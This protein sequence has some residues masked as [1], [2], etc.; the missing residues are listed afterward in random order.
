MQKCEFSETQ[1]FIGYARELFNSISSIYRIIA[2]STL[3]EKAY[4]ADLILEH[5][6]KRH[7][8]KFSVYYQFKRSHLHNKEI[9]SSLRGGN[10][11][12]T[13]HKR[14]YGFNIYNSI[15]TRQ[16]NVLQKLAT[17]P[18]SKVYYCAPLFHTIDK[19]DKHFSMS[20]I[21]RNSILFD[22]AD[23]EI[24]KV[25]IPLNSNHGFVFNRSEQYLCSDPVKIKGIVGNR[26]RF[27]KMLNEYEPIDFVSGID[28]E[29]ENFNNIFSDYKV[30]W[31]LPNIMNNRYIA[32]FD[33][34]EW[35]FRVLDIHWFP[36]FESDKN[37]S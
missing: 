22:M 15:K 33:Y 12:D 35:L 19:Y 30:K 11:L 31:K 6:N 34:S 10:V 28:L 32:F 2:P 4:A 7:V 17:K 1:F 3:A 21:K 37:V 23:D 9:F 24:Q 36:I 14:M 29:I 18:R 20:T 26:I 25:R 8:Y 13:K 27:D 5:F 16:F